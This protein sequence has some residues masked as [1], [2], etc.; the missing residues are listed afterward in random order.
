MKI[1]NWKVLLAILLHASGKVTGIVSQTYYAALLYRESNAN[2]TLTVSM[3]NTG[4]PEIN[5]TITG[6]CPSHKFALWEQPVHICTDAFPR[7]T[8]VTKTGLKLETTSTEEVS[9]QVLLK[10]GDKAEGYMAYPYEVLGKEYYI[11]TFCAF[12]STVCQFAVL[13]TNNNTYLKIDFINVS[14]KSQDQS[15]LND[16]MITLKLNELDVLQV[17][18]TR[19]LTG[20]HIISN[21]PVA[22]FAGSRSNLS[23]D[24]SHFI[25]QLLPVKLWGTEF[26]LKPGL[27][28]TGDFIQIIAGEMNTKVEMTGYPP[29]IMP[30][31]GQYVQKRLE[32]GLLYHLLSDYPIQIAQFVSINLYNNSVSALTAML[33][34][35]PVQLS[36]RTFAFSCLAGANLTM[37]IKKQDLLKPS[38][39]LNIDPKD[40]NKNVTIEYVQG[41]LYAVKTIVMQSTVAG[42]SNPVMQHNITVYGTSRTEFSGYVA[43]NDSSVMSITIP[44]TPFAFGCHETVMHV[45]DMRDNDCD[46]EV[47][48][49]NC[50]ND[51]LMTRFSLLKS[52]VEFAVEFRYFPFKEND[53]LHFRVQSC[54]IVMFTVKD[55]YDSR[56]FIL[57]VLE[58]SNFFVT[59]CNIYCSNSNKQVTPVT[60]C[61]DEYR[62]FSIFVNKTDMKITFNDSTLY[63]VPLH[64]K[65]FRK[66]GFGAL[67]Q[68]AEFEI[69]AST[70]DCSGMMPDRNYSQSY[71]VIY[72]PYERCVTDITSANET[73]V[74][75]RKLQP[76]SIFNAKVFRIGRLENFTWIKQ[77]VQNW[78]SI[79]VSANTELFVST[80]CKTNPNNRTVSF[81]SLPTALMGTHFIL[82]DTNNGEYMCAFATAGVHANVYIAFATNISVKITVDDVLSNVDYGHQFYISNYSVA[83]IKSNYNLMGS[84]VRSDNPIAVLC[85]SMNAIYSTLVQIP[86]IETFG[87]KFYIP[88]VDVVNSTLQN[89][90]NVTLNVISGYDGTNTLR[91]NDFDQSY[92]LERVGD[93]IAITIFG[94][95]AYALAATKPVLVFLSFISSFGSSVIIV[96]STD[97]YSTINFIPH[98]LDVENKL[99]SSWVLK[100]GTKYADQRDT[101]YSE[102]LP[103]SR[104]KD[105]AMAIFG[106]TLFFSKSLGVALIPGALVSKTA[107][108]C[109]L[110]PGYPG[111]SI[112]NDCDGL[113]D[114][115]F[116]FQDIVPGS[117]GNRSGEEYYSVLPCGTSR[118]TNDTRPFCG[119]STPSTTQINT[120]SQTG[121]GFTYINNVSLMASTQTTVLSSR[122]YY[123]NTGPCDCSVP[124]AWAW[125]TT[126]SEEEV[127]QEVTKLKK[128][129]AVNKDELAATIRSKISIK[130]FRPS[131][132][133]LGVLGI[134]LLTLTVGGIVILDITTLVRDFRRLCENLYDMWNY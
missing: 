100:D 31:K 25:E 54:G 102:R 94:N 61:M 12:V 91:S 112:D 21:K 9:V 28:A 83:W 48:E 6:A 125:N 97:Q 128:K 43:C 103:S 80:F 113:K 119:S 26:I 68:Q 39:S 8:G 109:I 71:L 86:P 78:T 22:V 76:G 40:M 87:T 72:P 18:S 81:V 53:Y 14:N 85:G 24:P 84:V 66:I 23:S 1:H 64:G 45:G 62:H 56:N 110:S 115:E 37:I 69:E 5:M 65:I 74:A 34:V 96:P 75:I 60:K 118:N 29:F 107:K 93:A 126:M 133:S 105:D 98:V 111:D 17:E 58:N 77:P 50:T 30:E 63:S 10:T 121:N 134:I 44:K 129:L 41:S 16:T 117:I 47:D 7:K 15:N 38:Q 114:E 70:Q 59:V 122:I 116:C 46:G 99:G 4:S 55:M 33:V 20:V 92:D 32:K 90:T 101:N 120:A 67:L 88:D 131:A 82:M 132:T 130:D 106:F 35:Q 11:T 127:K 19:S 52:P 13:A 79:I 42:F 123:D 124:C 36:A 73:E 57:M 104:Q 3:N 95:H 2:A 27:S 49:D 89:A 108:T 51:D